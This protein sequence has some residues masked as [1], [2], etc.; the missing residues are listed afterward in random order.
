MWY[1]YERQ[2][3]FKDGYVLFDNMPAKCGNLYQFKGFNEQEP[4]SCAESQRVKKKNG[5]HSRSM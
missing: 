2:L 3:L 5:I 4:H 1:N